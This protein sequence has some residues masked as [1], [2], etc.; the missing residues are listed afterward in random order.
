MQAS[1]VLRNSLWLGTLCLFAQ[2]PKPAPFN[3]SD[4]PRMPARA[5]VN[6]YQAHARVGSVNIGAEFMRHVVPTPQSEF[7]TENYVVVEIGFYGRAGD[8]INPAFV[9]E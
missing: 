5:S 7:S 6:D 3:P 1:R 8:K 2:D 9:G 4:V